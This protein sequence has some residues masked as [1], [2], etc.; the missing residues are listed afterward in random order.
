MTLSQYERPLYSHA[1]GRGAAEVE[2]IYVYTH[3]CMWSLYAPSRE[4]KLLQAVPS[5]VVN[6]S[7]YAQLDVPETRPSAC[8]AARQPFRIPSACAC[9]RK[10]WLRQASAVPFDL[11]PWLGGGYRRLTAFWTPSG[12]NLATMSCWKKRPLLRKQTVR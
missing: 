1:Q 3:R 12:R 9:G 7:L 5:L 2:K 10:R 6:L 4:Q 11:T 8:C